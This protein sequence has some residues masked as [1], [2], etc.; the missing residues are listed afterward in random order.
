MFDESTFPCKDKTKFPA[1]GNLPGEPERIAIVVKPI[2]GDT[3][4]RTWTW[5]KSLGNSRHGQAQQGQ[6][7]QAV[8]PGHGHE[9]E[10]DEEYL[11]QY[12]TEELA[13]YQLAGDRAKRLIIQNQRYSSYLELIFTALVA[14]G[15]V[16]CEE[17][18]SELEAISSKDRISG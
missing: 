15:E 5:E 12:Q 11:D 17:P 6:E 10:R 13:N 1:L 2:L 16:K 9:P 8:E 4:P 14:V 18:E 7:D 3:Y